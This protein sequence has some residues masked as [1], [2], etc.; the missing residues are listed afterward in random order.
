MAVGVSSSLFGKQPGSKCAAGGENAATRFQDQ[1]ATLDLQWE[2]IRMGSHAIKLAM[3]GSF[4]IALL[5]LYF[6][7]TS[8][9]TP[10]SLSA[11]AMYI[12]G[13]VVGAL[14]SMSANE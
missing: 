5:G 14:L 6:I 1:L 13:A 12:V 2:E 8:T 7:F 3:A 10:M 11:C 4:G 9:S